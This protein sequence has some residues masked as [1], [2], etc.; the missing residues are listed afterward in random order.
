MLSSPTSF[1][2]QNGHSMPAV[3]IRKSLA[4]GKMRFVFN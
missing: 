4:S 2:K 1:E 3:D